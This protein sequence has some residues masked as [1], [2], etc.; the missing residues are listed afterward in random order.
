MLNINNARSKSNITFITI[1]NKS[2]P[3]H[4]YFVLLIVCLCICVCECLLQNNNLKSKHKNHTTSK[5]HSCVRGP[6]RECR[7]IRSCTSGLPYYCTPRVCIS[8]VI[9][10]LAMWRHNIPKTQKKNQKR[11]SHCGD[12]LAQG[13]MPAHQHCDLFYPLVGDLIGST[14]N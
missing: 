7:S 3:V 11:K 14:I 4:V 2:V 13:Y 10:L 8:A 12:W 5:Q 9:G 1:Q 6:L